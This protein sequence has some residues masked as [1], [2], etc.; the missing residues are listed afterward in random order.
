MGGKYK[1]MKKIAQYIPHKN[2]ELYVEPFGG[3][4][5]VLLYK[6]KWAESEVFNDLD[7]N[8]VNLFRQVKYHPEELL[9]ELD[10]LLNSRE[11]FEYFKENPGITDIERAARYLYLVQFSFAGLRNSYNHCIIRDRGSGIRS[12]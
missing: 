1:T 5:W 11:I 4:G 6:D 2:I 8:I 12:V 9:N 7:G 10:W 3:A